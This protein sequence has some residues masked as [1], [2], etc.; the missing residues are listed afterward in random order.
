MNPLQINLAQY[1]IDE[2][3]SYTILEKFNNKEIG[4][5]PRA[6][7]KEIPQIDNR[8]ILDCTG[9]ISIHFNESNVRRV[10]EKFNLPESLLLKCIK[11]DFLFDNELLSEIGIHLYPTFSYGVLNG[12]S[13]T[14]YADRKKNEDFNSELF[15]NFESLFLELSTSYKGKAKGITPAFINPNGEPG[16]SFMELKMR[17]LLI[18]AK[19]Y[20]EVTGNSNTN[21]FPMFQMTSTYNN[22][23]IHDFYRT[24]KDSK[25]I[26]SL[27][28]ET[29]I[30]I[31]NVLTGV[32]PLI[33]A[34]THSKDGDTKSIFLTENN[35]PLPLPGGHGQCFLVLKSVFN[36]LFNK[37]IRFITIGNVDNVGYTL[38]PKS[39]ALLALSEK[40][41]AFDFSFK[42]E[43]DVK[44]GVLIRDQFDRINC[45]DLG[46]AVSKEDIKLAEES[47]TP[48][49]FN[50]AT[51]M[52]NLEYLINNIDN[53]IIKLPTR[54]SDQNKDIGKYSQGEQ[55]TWEVIGLLDDFLIMAIDKYDRFLASKLLLENLVTSGLTCDNIDENLKKSGEALNKGL[56]KKL[57]DDFK[58][59]LTNGRWE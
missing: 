50:C 26:K 35:E 57:K 16:P 53:I 21:L 58:L 31:T 55:V 59:T 52:F 24:C 5:E 13:A 51:G 40:Q 11:S 17:S 28:H 22:D 48:I 27:A 10:F 30:D 8:T 41:A 6:Q 49:L 37:G 39:L 34:Y 42:T 1:G 45:A 2:K 9:N 38:D 12:G 7:L 46:V 19:K 33:S 32:Q 14:S 4:Q 56:F 43:F 18:E 3:L 15:N 44:G 25:Y 23:D 54:F 29:G 20:K 36:E 47:K